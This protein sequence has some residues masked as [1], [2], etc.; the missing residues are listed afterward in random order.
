MGFYSLSDTT[1]TY[2]REQVAAMPTS[3][4]TVNNL[5]ISA[6]TDYALAKMYEILAY[7]KANYWPDVNITNIQAKISD[8]S[9]KVAPPPPIFTGAT[10]AAPKIAAMAGAYYKA[11]LGIL[12]LP[13]KA[14]SVAGLANDINILKTKYIGYQYSEDPRTLITDATIQSLLVAKSNWESQGANAAATATAAALKNTPEK[15]AQ[16][17]EPVI[18]QTPFTELIGPG[19]VQPSTSLSIE[20]QVKSA[21]TGATSKIESFFQGTYNIAGHNVSKALVWGGAAAAVALYMMSEN[22]ARKQPSRRQ[23]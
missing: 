4:V 19:G 23:G 13:Y 14:E 21:V 6:P 15:I 10:V 7:A 2:T 8:Y 18:I 11:A 22:P 17:P 3:Y 16:T 9:K 20:Q 5:A 12:S 1:T